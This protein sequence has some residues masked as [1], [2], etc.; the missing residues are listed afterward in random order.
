[1][2]KFRAS[3]RSAFL[4]KRL[5]NIL[6]VYMLLFSAQGS[7]IRKNLPDNSGFRFRCILQSVF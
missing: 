1:M 3:W 2:C 5:L 4:D 6:V 7:L